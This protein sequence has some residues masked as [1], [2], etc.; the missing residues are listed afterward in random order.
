M[1]IVDGLEPCPQKYLK[2]AEEEKE[3]VLNPEYLIWNKKDQ[4]LLSVITSSLSEKVLAMVYGLNT[5]HQ[6]WTALATKFASKSKSRIA[7]LKKQLQNLSQGSKSCSDY[8]QTAKILANQLNAT[9]NPIPDKEIIYAILNGL[10]ASFNHFITIYSFHTRV[11]DISFE[12]FQ[13]YPPFSFVNRPKHLEDARRR[14][15]EL[16]L[17]C[18]A[19][20]SSSKRQSL[21]SLV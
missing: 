14:L 8:I 9:G 6:A 3:E 17:P 18:L 4:Y 2:D 10:H 13:E 21:Y 16:G 11:S 19:V 7:N 15:W 1:G 5:S 20:F 12:D